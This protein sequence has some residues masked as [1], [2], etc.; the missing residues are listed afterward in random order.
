VGLSYRKKIAPGLTLSASRRGLGASQRIGVPGAGVSVN[1]RG[2]VTASAGAGGVRYQ[3]SR[4][5]GTRRSTRSANRRIPRPVVV[6]A[7]VFA[8]FYLLSVAIAG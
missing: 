1:S 3:K 6:G 8:L 2:R 4:T 5:M 7:V